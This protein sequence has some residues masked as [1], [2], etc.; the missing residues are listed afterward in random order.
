MKISAI[1]LVLSTTSLVASAV[2]A[3]KIDTG[4]ALV[5][6]CEAF[7]KLDENTASNAVHPHYCHQ[8]LVG[9]FSAFAEGDQAERNARI[10]FSQGAKSGACVR[11]PEFL[12]YRDMAT[13]V[14]A[15]SKRDPSL[16]QGP[17][18]T[19]AQRTLEYDFP[20]AADKRESP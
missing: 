20:C 12:S 13:R 7:G 10:G 5:S 9:F 18:T 11:L 2:A 6:A 3:Q 15:Q 19:L 17:A 8:F 16:L 14:V 4:A 1:L